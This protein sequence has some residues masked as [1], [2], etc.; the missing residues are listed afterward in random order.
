MNHRG[1]ERFVMKRIDDCK[2]IRIFKKKT[3]VSRSLFKAD[4]FL[5]LTKSRNN[6][7]SCSNAKTYNQFEEN[8]LIKCTTLKDQI[9]TIS[10]K[11][12]FNVGN[13]FKSWM[14]YSVAKTT[15]GMMGRRGEKLK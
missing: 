15:K 6:S 12:R 13:I 7:L 8:R 1:L 9:K 14:R 3:A 5:Y 4:Q 11:K 10:K 2:S